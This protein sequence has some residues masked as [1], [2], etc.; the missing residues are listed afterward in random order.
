[1]DS[2]LEPQELVDLFPKG[3]MTLSMIGVRNSG[4][5]VLIQQIIKALC[6]KKLVDIVLVM[7]GSAQL[8][9]DYNFLPEG[10]VMP[11]SSDM[12]HRIWD[13]QLK[14]KKEGKQKRVF[15]VF[16]DCLTDKNAI[17]NE[18]MMRIYV[19]GRHISLGSA[20]LSQYPAYITSP[21][22]LGNSDCI[23]YSKL[24]RQAIERLWESTSGI[25]K[26]DFIRVSEA[27]AGVNYTFMVINNY[28][29]SPDPAMYL[30]FVRGIA[31]KG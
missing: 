5:S 18:I 27:V 23:L 19:Q 28:C 10:T 21:T 29:K 14:E 26:K 15:I 22:I 31:E 20:I 3:S 8:N 25:S 16:D 30:R 7:S 11:F 2:A 24:N 6:K 1:M 17:R 12:L 13:K 9:D 4:K